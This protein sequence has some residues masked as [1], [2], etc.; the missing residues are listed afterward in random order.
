MAL[1]NVSTS[2]AARVEVDVVSALIPPVLAA[3]FIGGHRSRELGVAVNETVLIQR[4]HGSLLTFAF[5]ALRRTA[6]QTIPSCA[7]RSRGDLDA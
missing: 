1:L 5:D 7:T 6:L 4:L 2:L 3:S